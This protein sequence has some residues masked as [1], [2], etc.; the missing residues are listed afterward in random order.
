MKTISFPDLDLPKELERSIKDLGFE[1]PTPIQALS[2]PMLREGVD[3]IGQAHTGT[4]KTAAF[5]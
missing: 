1:E 3:V 5:G 2:I 4:G